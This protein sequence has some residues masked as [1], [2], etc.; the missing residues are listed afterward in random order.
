MTGVGQVSYIQSLQ[1]AVFQ[2][3]FLISSEEK[4]LLLG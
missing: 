1:A 3:Q 4:A 2:A